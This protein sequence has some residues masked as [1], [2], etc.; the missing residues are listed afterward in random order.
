MT[1]TGPRAAGL[2][3]LLAALGGV[4][5]ARA[6]GRPTEAPRPSAQIGHDLTGG[7]GH[8]HV[9]SA[10]T[11]RSLGLREAVTLASRRDPRVAVTT[12][13]RRAAE[14]RRDEALVGYAPD[15]L[16]GGAY[17][18]GFAGSGS[19][20][21]LRGMLGSPFFRNY[22]VGVD[23]SW[24][25]VELL[26]T[27]HG[28]RAAEAGVDATDASRATAVREVALAV[29]DLFE[30]ILTAGETRQVL[31]AEAATRRE[32]TGALRAR[33]EAGTVAREQLLQA[34]AGLSDVEAELATAT[35]EERSARTALRALIADDRALT[36]SV[37][38]ETTAGTRELPEVRI[39]RAFRRQAEELSTLR[40]MEWLP[41]LTVGGSA[42][43]ANPPPGSDPGHY[44]VG[45]GLALPL[46]ATFRERARR[47][48]DLASARARALEADGTLEQLAVR[49]AEIDGSIAGLEAALPAAERSRQAAEQALAAVTARAQAGAVPQVDVEAARAV[50]RR[51]RM[52][53]RML[54]LRVDGLRARRV[55]LTTNP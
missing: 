29:V 2:A 7:G 9:D 10:T 11:A 19:H 55:F 15:V 36:A 52:R 48:A 27:P 28:V 16:L 4:T 50:L 18:D 25:L 35:A 21:Q 6:Q 46:T 42:G 33:V 20:L 34:E 24:N 38:I 40:G 49:T 22:V 39:A 54:R 45:I 53:E 37:R 41:R 43:Y 12:A 14:A 32:Q 44:A 30:R 17:T 13:R 3:A 51:T 31:E 5:S 1:R 8:G 23:A 26:R 47:D